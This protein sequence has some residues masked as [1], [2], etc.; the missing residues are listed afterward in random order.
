MKLFVIN[1]IVRLCGNV[2]YYEKFSFLKKVI[3]FNNYLIFYFFILH[4][5]HN[6][7]YKGINSCG[8]EAENL[9]YDLHF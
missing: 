2:I 9:A 3:T 5:V 8:E 6:A 4:V 1:H 7:F